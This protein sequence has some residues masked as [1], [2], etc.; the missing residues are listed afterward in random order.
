LQ[1]RAERTTQTPRQLAGGMESRRYVEAG[2]RS[3]ARIASAA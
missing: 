1:Q 2:K 3:E